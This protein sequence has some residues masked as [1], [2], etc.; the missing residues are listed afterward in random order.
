MV[1]LLVNHDEIRKDIK[2]YVHLTQYV[3]NSTTVHIS[4]RIL[5]YFLDMKTG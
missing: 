4:M 1:E 3:M 5:S 2:F